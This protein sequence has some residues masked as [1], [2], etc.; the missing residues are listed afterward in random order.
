MQAYEMK[1]VIHNDTHFDNVLL[2]KTTE[3]EVE[4]I[5]GGTQQYTMDT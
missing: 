2:K 5:L 4:Y 3:K 1:G